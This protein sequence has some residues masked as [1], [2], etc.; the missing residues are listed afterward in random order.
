[1]DCF[2]QRGA[3][4]MKLGRGLAPVATYLYAVN[5]TYWPIPIGAG[6]FFAGKEEKALQVGSFYGSLDDTKQLVETEISRLRQHATK[7]SGLP[8][9]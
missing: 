6:L 4:S 3:A 2:H 8:N 7:Q 5:A 1:M 9:N